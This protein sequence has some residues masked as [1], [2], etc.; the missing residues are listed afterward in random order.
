MKWL[1]NEFIPLSNWCCL[2]NK[3]YWTT[4]T[5]VSVCWKSPLKYVSSTERPSWELRKQSLHWYLSLMNH[6][7]KML[8]LNEFQFEA[9]NFQWIWYLTYSIIFLIQNERE[10]PLLLLN[11]KKIG[12]PSYSEA[13]FN[14]KKHDHIYQMISLIVQPYSNNLKHDFI[15]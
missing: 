9:L 15:Q 8:T 10:M 11:S 6:W 5:H 12:Q 4:D 14:K 13:M 2:L 3:S 1:A 7:I